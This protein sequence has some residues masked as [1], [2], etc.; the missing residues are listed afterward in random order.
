[1]LH[2]ELVA[3]KGKFAPTKIRFTQWDSRE[4]EVTD[5]FGNHLRFWETIRLA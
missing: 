5:P 3:R 1:V 2:R 4:F